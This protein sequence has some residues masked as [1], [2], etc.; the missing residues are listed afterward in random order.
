MKILA[1]A[2]VIAS[3]A[4]SSPQILTSDRIELSANGEQTIVRA[5]EWPD[6]A[7]GLIA[8]EQ[9][10]SVD[11]DGN[12]TY[13]YARQSR[14][15]QIYHEAFC[16]EKN[17]RPAEGEAVLK[18]SI[19]AWVCELSD[20]DEALNPKPASPLQPPETTTHLN[21][22]SNY[23]VATAPS[24]SA[25]AGVNFHAT[26]T[27]RYSSSSSGSMRGSVSVDGGRCATDYSQHYSNPFSGSHIATAI[28]MVHEPRRVP[29]KMDGCV[30]KLCG[31]ANGSVTVN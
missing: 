23:V 30:P 27:I 12:P 6:F 3:P 24:G 16:L 25:S 11:N 9:R 29:T 7:G 19:A 20:A 15:T 18:G 28:C 26:G 2:L 31:S 14:A 10:L 4:H 17:A 1:L 8:V 13:Q 22:S 5:A 21:R